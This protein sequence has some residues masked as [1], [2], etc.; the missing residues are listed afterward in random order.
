MTI[1][2]YKREELKTRL[3][4]TSIAYGRFLASLYNL[5]NVI[6]ND[7]KD[8]IMVEDIIYTLDNVSK[9]R[10]HLRDKYELKLGED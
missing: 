8:A 10:H 7:T 2:P 6:I 5:R 1:P 9:M 4:E 3:R